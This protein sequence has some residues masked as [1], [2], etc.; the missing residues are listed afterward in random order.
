MPN[1][2]VGHFLRELR[3]RKVYRTAAAYGVVAFV[4]W[5]VADYLFPALGFP[6]WTVD[7]VVV[8][9]VLGFP[10]AL[11]LAWALEVTPDGVRRAAGNPPGEDASPA[12]PGPAPSAS[13]ESAGPPTGPAPAPGTTTE[14]VGR[15]EADRNSVAVLPFANMSPDPEQAYFGDGIAEEILNAL[16]QLGDLNVAARTS[17]FA[18]RDRSIDIREMGRRLGVG[19]VLEG[20]VRRSGDRVRVTAQLVATDDGYHLWSGTFDRTYDDIFAIQDEVTEAV[21]EALRVELLDRERDRLSRAG[22]ESTEAYELYLKGRHFWHRRYQVG[23]ETSV[24][25]FERALAIDPEFALAHAGLSNALVVMGIYGM[26]S[27][28]KSKGAAVEA[29][30]RAVELGPELPES[31][32]ARGMVL[33]DIRYDLPAAGKAYLRALE[34]DR[35]Y[36]PAWVWLG[37]Y[38]EAAVSDLGTDPASAADRA[39][40]LEPDSD[41]VVAAA[42]VVHQFAGRQD[43]AVRLLDRVLARNPE[44]VLAL[45]ARGIAAGDRGDHGAAITHLERA[46]A[47]SNRGNFALMVLGASLARAGSQERAR[48]IAAELDVRRAEHGGYVPDLFRAALR[49]SLGERREALDLLEEGIRRS[50]QGAGPVVA[51]G[52]L[53][54]LRGEPRFEDVVRRLGLRPR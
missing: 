20:S 9:S 50:P 49:A 7:F 47:L 42:G 35:S 15:R 16:T 21:V 6:A 25:C 29:A 51:W 52:L 12:G 44:H 27:P 40:A 34:L 31:H 22:T 43:R 45:L 2:S 28:E 53:D 39:A 17:S 1:P 46:A 48:S 38:G 30:E 23:L 26:V 5:Q 24:E 10:L 18:Y 33:G 8:L 37:L 54:P 36:S 11:V 14:A 41:Y 3:R 32:F 4:V 13:E 19:H